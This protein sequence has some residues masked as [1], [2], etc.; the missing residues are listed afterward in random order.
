VQKL[1][2]NGIYLEVSELLSPLIYFYHDSPFSFLNREVGLT[3]TEE[4]DLLERLKICIDNLFDRFGTPSVVAQ[5]N[6]FYT[7]IVDGKHS[8]AQG[9]DIPNFNAIIDNPESEEAIH[10]AAFVR[11][12]VKGEYMFG[13]N[14]YDANWSKSFWNESYKLDDCEFKGQMDD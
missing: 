4:M 2:S 5:L 3:I 9:M 8:F 7:R 10:A 6:V 1:I 14:D 12:S 11:N 13:L